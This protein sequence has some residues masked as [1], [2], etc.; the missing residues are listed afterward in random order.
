ML[1]DTRP[2]SVDI[3]CYGG[4]DL[5]LRINVTGADYSGADWTAEVRAD[6]DS[7]VDAT[8]VCA[9]DLTGG[10][11]TLLGADADALR[12]IDNAPAPAYGAPFSS[13]VL[14]YRGVW[15]VQVDNGGPVK[16][17]VQGVIEVYAD[18]TQ[19]P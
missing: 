5:S 6:H 9:P 1:I 4:D 8:L 12:D 13:T 3:K 16:T 15:D 19:V 7:P 14:K 17:L 10:T 18:V 11:V 2:A